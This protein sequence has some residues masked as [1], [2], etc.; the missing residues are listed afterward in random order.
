MHRISCQARNAYDIA[1]SMICIY[2]LSRVYAA[3]G[4]YMVRS[5]FLERLRYVPGIYNGP[6]S[7][8]TLYVII[9][10]NSYTYF[11]RV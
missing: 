10:T 1:C 8:Y 6:T 11:V 2:M 5:K 7:T 9:H 3:L 4:T